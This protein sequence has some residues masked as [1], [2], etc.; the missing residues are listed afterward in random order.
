M[1]EKIAKNYSFCYLQEQL[2]EYTN[3]VVG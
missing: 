1:Y 2:V 3:R